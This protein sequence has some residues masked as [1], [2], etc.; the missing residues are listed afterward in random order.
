MGAHDFG[1]GCGLR[2]AH[3]GRDRQR[4]ACRGVFL[5]AHG[6]VL[7]QIADWPYLAAVPA[8]LEEGQFS[9][10]TF[11]QVLD[12]G[13]ELLKDRFVADEPIE[14][15]VRDRAR[16]VDIALRAA[17]INH[18][19]KFAGDL[20]LVAVGGYGRGALPPSSHITP[21]LPFPHTT[22]PAPTPHLHRSH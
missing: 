1:H 7:D 13:T 20:A 15:L 9:P 3:L 18:T 21:P 17:W 14:D 6:F 16:L 22:S 11:R 12:Q 19:G 8:A 4:A 5:N 2:G 10:I